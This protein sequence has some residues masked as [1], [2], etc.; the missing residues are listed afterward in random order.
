M[1]CSWR[2]ERLY[3]GGTAY[4]RIYSSPIATRAAFQF[5]A[6]IESNNPNS[7][8]NFISRKI[9]VHTA[10]RGREIPTLQITLSSAAQHHP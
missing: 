7:I 6:W 2:A 1:G 9:T 10:L 4:T 5:S 8:D 3:Q